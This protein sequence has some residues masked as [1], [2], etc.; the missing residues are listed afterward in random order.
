MRWRQIHNL[1]TRSAK[2]MGVAKKRRARAYLFPI[3]PEPA[4]LG[5]EITEVPSLQE[6]IVAEPY[7]RHDV[8]ST[9]SDLLCFGKE[10]VHATIQG[11]FPNILDWDELLWPYLGR[12]ENVKVELVFS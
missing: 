9:E 8:A 3:C 5:V 4:L 7:A 6:G 11:H 12:V 10:L 1:E 2:V